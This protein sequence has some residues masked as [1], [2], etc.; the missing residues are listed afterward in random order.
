[1]NVFI[2]G[3]SGAIGRQLV[4]MLVQ[5]GH[6]VVAM[7]RTEQGA[8]ALQA[9][10][11]TPVLADVFDAARLVDVVQLAQPEVVIHQ[12]TAFGTPADDPQQETIRVRTEGTRNLVDAARKSSARC[13]I[14]QS[15]S[16]MC[17]PIASGLTD[18]DTPLYLDAAPAI[19][20]LAQSI[21]ELERQTLRH[22][23]LHGVVLRYG[24]FYGP[25]TNYDP[26]GVIPRAIRR[27]RMAIVGAGDG[28][29]SFVHVHDAAVATMNALLHA[30][31][32]IYNIVD[33][34]PVRLKHWLPVA[35]RL[36]DAPAPVPMD[37][38]LARQ[39][40]GDLMV[41]IYNEQSGASNQKAKAALRWQPAIPSWQTGFEALY[42]RV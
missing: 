13:F 35:A 2:A 21:A 32:G 17:T 25:G 4:P 6:S 12:L 23:D 11:A 19:R 29:Y 1:L 5:A 40:M 36:L 26:D 27:G 7:T 22:E 16:F 14:T 10:G 20:P 24:W 30:Q 38:A 28:T 15:I 39:K 42:S 3:G 33:D 31:P 41:Y 8:A 37:E 18:E 9:M 34:A